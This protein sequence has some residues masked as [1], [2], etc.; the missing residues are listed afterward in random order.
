[1]KA[2]FEYAIS[3]EGQELAA[4]AA[5]SAPLSAGLTKKVEAAVA[6]IE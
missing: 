6:A 4:E 1:V 2:Y 3:P 5:G